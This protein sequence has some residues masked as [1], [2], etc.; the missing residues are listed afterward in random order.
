M[1]IVMLYTSLFTGTPCL[2]AI[3][4]SRMSIIFKYLAVMSDG[5]QGACNSMLDVV[6]LNTMFHY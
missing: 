3:T 1:L 2:L 4:Q 6:K 5:G